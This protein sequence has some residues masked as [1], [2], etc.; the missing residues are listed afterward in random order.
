MI[1]ARYRSYLGLFVAQLAIAAAT[2]LGRYALQ[3][4]SPTVVAALRMAFASLPLLALALVQRERRL[5]WRVE[6]VLAVAGA[7]LAAHFIIWLASLQYASI[8]VSTLL[9]C[10]SPLWNS[11]YDI[12]VLRRMPPA[13]FIAGLVASLLGLGLVVQGHATSVTPPVPG[14]PGWGAALA[15]AGAMLMSLYLGLV[16]HVGTTARTRGFVCSTR[17]VV[18]RTFTWAALDLLALI[19]LRDEP[20]PSAEATHAWAGIIGMA[21]F[22]QLVGHTLMNSAVRTFAAS[23]VA[24]AQLLIP[25]FAAGLA[26]LIF[27]EHLTARM[28]VG[29]LLILAGFATALQGNDSPAVEANAA[30]SEAA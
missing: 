7:V 25:V 20:L 4:A 23:L 13:L 15:I 14:H 5:P 24:L 1:A 28:C 10:S 9:V 3:G 11:L 27:Q 8:A 29:S 6:A 21:V 16:E 19:A 22:S 30:A 12:V 18:T 17:S 2:I 26:A